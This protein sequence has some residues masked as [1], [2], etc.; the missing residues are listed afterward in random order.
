MK[1]LGY[2]FYLFEYYF[3][4]LSTA[5][6]F[7]FLLIWLFTGYSAGVSTLV[8]PVRWATNTAQ[9]HGLSQDLENI[10]IKII[11]ILLVL[12]TAVFSA[13]LTRK[14]IQSHEARLKAGIIILCLVSAMGSLWLMENPSLLNIYEDIGAISGTQFTFGP[15]PTKDI[16]TQLKGEGY[17][18][19]ISLLHPAVVPFEPQLL[20][21]EKKMISEIGLKFIH[22]PML[23]WVGEGLNEG[24]LKKL[25][26]I[27]ASAKGRY[28]IHCYL[29]KDRVRLAKRII[30]AASPTSRTAALVSSRKIDNLN[31]FERGYIIKL[32]DGVYLTPFPTDDEF[33]AYILSGNINHVV[34][35]LAPDDKEDSKWIEKERSLLKTYHIPF[36]NLPLE[37]S[38]FDPAEV[39]EAAKKART[40]S[41]PVVIHAFRSDSSRAQ[42]FIQAFR[43]NVPPLP[44]GSFDKPLSAGKTAVI[45]PNVAIGPRPSKDEFSAVLFQRGVRKVLYLGDAQTPAAKNDSAYSKNAGLEWSSMAAEIP[46][47]AVMESVSSGGP[48]YI[49]GGNVEAKMIGMAETLERGKIIKLGPE[50]YLTPFPTDD[51]FYRY[52]TSGYIKQVVAL[53]D[54][55]DPAEAQWLAREKRILK[56]GKIPL[57]VMKIS[58]SDYDPEKILAAA[59]KT[60]D[61]PHPVVIHASRTFSPRSMAFANAF[62]TNLPPLTQTLFKIPLQ[63]GNASVIAPNI[64]VGPDP[65]GPEFGSYLH[66]RGVRRFLYLGNPD[67]AVS[68]RD[69][70][71]AKGANLDWQALDPESTNIY[72]LVAKGGPWYLYGPELD[73]V[74][75]NIKRRLGPPLPDIITRFPE[76]ERIRTLAQIENLRPLLRSLMSSG[77]P[78]KEVVP[79]IRMIIL[80][81]PFL[82]VYTILSA[83][84]AGWLKT[85]KNMRAPYTRKIFHFLIFSFASFLLIAAGFP[86]LILFGTIVTICVIYAIYSGQGFPFYEAIARPTDAP[87]RT[88][89]VVIPLL[90]T[91]LGGLLGILFFGKL[92]AVGILISGWGD[93]VGEPVGTLWGRHKYRVPAFG[94]LTINRSLEG[95][96]AIALVGILGALF[97]M[98]F[99]GFS[100]MVA[101]KVGLTCGLLGALVEA[102]S[103]HGLDNLTVQIITTA[104]AYFMIT[105]I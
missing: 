75:A 26:E 67:S 77:T 76:T 13:W 56:A 21:D 24:S 41:G 22:L 38:G 74:K 84:F 45:G 10:I 1:K 3:F 25:E 7:L 83:A 62:R 17:T 46:L 90:M 30:E 98:I 92:A 68:K 29:G 31:R 105:G 61:F 8:G 16:L 5:N 93:A 82:L 39:L 34:S 79:D 23:P 65:A 97:G 81:G 19:I 33:T 86:V 63:K 11:I 85:R 99:A 87:Y 88:I 89:Y 91:G 96:L 57:K 66:T 40:L 42:A 28:Y 95:S 18:T 103:S 50:V 43:R 15:Y 64:A 37:K 69:S 71:I 59:R 100:P 48:W 54:P 27:A 55:D 52:I 6:I 53:L 104:T 70:V 4:R 47:K 44:P 9:A 49:Y 32:A 60:W 80:L 12:L 36:D 73:D 94:H 101:L 14:I 78:L 20:A 72:D 58:P 51:E 2:Y 102:I 35:L